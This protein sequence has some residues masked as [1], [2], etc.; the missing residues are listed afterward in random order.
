MSEFQDFLKHQYTY[1]AKGEFKPGKFDEAQALYEKAV[2]TYEQGFKGAYLLREP[3]SDKGIAVIFW[4]S[5][6]D[7]L[8]SQTEEYQAI[9]KQMAPLFATP[10]ETYMYEVVAEIKPKVP[11]NVN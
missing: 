3:E 9:L 10:P 6:E 11:A 5:V 2:S 8:N 7:M 1:V 4:E